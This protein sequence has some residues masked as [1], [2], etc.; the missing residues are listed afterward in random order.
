MGQLVTEALQGESHPHLPAGIRALG[1]WHK[2]WDKQQAGSGG[3]GRAAARS[4]PCTLP[5]HRDPTQNR[6]WGGGK[7]THFF[8]TKR[9]KKPPQMNLD[10]TVSLTGNC[11]LQPKAFLTWIPYLES[12]LEQRSPWLAQTLTLES[13]RLHSRDPPRTHQGHWSPSGVSVCSEN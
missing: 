9:Q 1:T 8:V 12:S 13:A 2:R 4:G 11:L 5:S 7:V 3:Q 10:S 6:G